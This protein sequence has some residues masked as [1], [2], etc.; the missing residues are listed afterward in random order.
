MNYQKTKLIELGNKLREMYENAPYGDSVT[1]IHIF[2][3]K[4]ANEI[5]QNGFT[6]GNIIKASGINS[7]YATEVSKGIRL[8]KYVI[9]KQEKDRF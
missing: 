9:I 1:M 5:K 7:S 3:I 2:G 8:A 6:V 4:Y